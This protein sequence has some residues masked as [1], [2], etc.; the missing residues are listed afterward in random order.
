MHALAVIYVLREI[1]AIRQFQVVQ[2]GMDELTVRIVP[3]GELSA[4]T[5]PHIISRLERLFDGP[6]NIQIEL[7]ETLTSPSG[8][9]RYVISAVANERLEELL[10][11]P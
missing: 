4:A 11:A 10:R 7:A 9:H 1:P 2:E 8:K 3:E 5:R 6:V